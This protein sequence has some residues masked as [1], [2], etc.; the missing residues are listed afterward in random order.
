LQLKSK[1]RGCEDLGPWKRAICNHLWWCA[2][3]CN[4]DKEW[5]EERFTSIIYHSINE[6]I[7]EGDI[8][9]SCAHE[10]I[11]LDMA[12]KQKLFD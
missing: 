4:G 11:P 9:T 1:A 6:H 8:V 2:T 7:F 3:N 10:E 12:R 5:L